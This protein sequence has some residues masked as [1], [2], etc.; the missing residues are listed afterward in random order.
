[1]VNESQLEAIKGFDDTA[2]AIDNV[3]KV[4]DGLS[5]Q[6]DAYIKQTQKTRVENEKLAKQQLKTTKQE[7]KNIKKII[8]PA[9]KKLLSTGTLTLEGI[10]KAWT[11]ASKQQIAD[12]ANVKEEFARAYKYLLD[13]GRL[14]L[15]QIEGIWGDLEK[16]NI[17]ITDDIKEGFI[18]AYERLF[19]AADISIDQIKAIWD[20]L[21]KHNLQVTDNIK[22]A[23]VR[24]FTEIVTSA[25]T[26][27]EDIMRAWDFMKE[28][29]IQASEELK[30]AT[31]N[32]L[33]EI[34]SATGTTV[35]TI[36]SIWDF[37]K[38]HNIQVNETIKNAYIRAN[39]DILRNANST[40]DQVREAW[41]RLRQLQL[42]VIEAFS[43]GWNY[44]YS[45][46]KSKTQM[47][48]EFGQTTAENLRQAFSNTFYNAM[49]G[50][51]NSLKG[52][53]NAFCS[54]LK[55]RFFRL[56]ADIAA[57]RI[58]MFFKS[59]WA[60]NPWGRGPI[61]SLLGID[62]PF[63]TFAGGGEVPGIWNGK[64]GFAGDTVIAAL[65]PGEWV[66]PRDVAQIPEVKEF[67]KAI[68]GEAGRVAHNK[69]IPARMGVQGLAYGGIVH[70]EIPH[71]GFFGS[72]FGGIFGGLKK[73]VSGIFGAVSKIT[74]WISESTLG[75]IV[76]GIGLAAAAYMFPALAPAV[77][78]GVAF[79][80]AISALTSGFDLGDILSGA[81]TGG[82]YGVATAGLGRLWQT[83]PY[84][85]VAL[86]EKY[87]AEA[88]SRGPL[89]GLVANVGRFAKNVKSV[90]TG[91]PST[92]ASLPRRA[93]EAV[94]SIAKLT[95][96]DVFEQLVSLPRDAI[97]ALKD[98]ATKKW[99]DVVI[100]LRG[101]ATYIYKK[102]RRILYTPPRVG[103]L[104]REAWE[105][106]KQIPQS[107]WD[108]ILELGRK[109]LEFLRNFNLV[110]FVADHFGNIISHL[111]LLLV[112]AAGGQA[113]SNIGGKLGIGSTQSFLAHAG[114]L[115]PALAGGGEVSVIARPYEYVIRPESARS[116]GYNNLDYINRTGQLPQT[117][118]QT[119]HLNLEVHVDSASEPVVINKVI[120]IIRNAS[121]SGMAVIHER[122][123]IRED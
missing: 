43:A 75:K 44:A 89:G 95:P 48:M 116:V 33:T 107:A 113:L 53:W 57:N 101:K 45:N 51:I 104:T 4:F 5:K 103:D 123:I 86:M 68:T 120:P 18:N 9:Y 117:G 106:F 35:Q 50:K 96:S 93:L 60:G 73:I 65:T 39:L 74:K 114:G 91:I 10:R 109:G 72:L 119:I 19:K 82:V 122:A 41:E 58:M 31:V 71:F 30:K 14:R 29:N 11:A 40:A 56:V 83:P 76:S 112:G 38:E 46:F 8:I 23:T 100:A 17:K 12:T 2:A 105:R 55:A 24:R 28:H 62:V 7:E 59:A 88:A 16:H 67:L 118:P 110:S 37:M 25:S 27:L 102:G 98:L 54:E 1:V 34:A 115:I 26:S 79:G 92:L 78:K 52:V 97:L 42:S 69:N 6:V 108:A 84:K 15:K 22:Q 36:N 99:E 49:M 87:A 85:S 81:L 13:T 3:D 90:V 63:L 21:E 20:S 70:P 111:R 77:L 61:E 47:I 64:R 32:R 121:K 66:V 80:A 94:W